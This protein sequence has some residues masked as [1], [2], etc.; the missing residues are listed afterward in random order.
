MSDKLIA[1]APAAAMVA[2]A[3]M[4]GLL[5]LQTYEQ[6]RDLA[7]VIANSD[8]APKDF[9]GKPD[10][11]L[12]A[13]IMGDE[14]GLAPMQ[15]VQNIAVINGRPS[16]WGDAVLALVRSSGLCAAFREWT[17]GEG[18]S[19]VA[20]CS[21]T[22]RDDP[23]SICQ[24]MFS[25]GDAKRAGLWGKQG[26]WQQYPARMLQM[27]A[28]GFALR[29]TYPDVLRGIWTREEAEDISPEPVNVTPPPA[30]EIVPAPV[31][32]Q[33]PRKEV[34]DRWAKG[35][36]SWAEHAVSEQTLREYVGL[37]PG[38]D[39]GAG[40]LELLTMAWREMKGGRTPEQIFQTGEVPPLLDREVT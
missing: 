16:L 23:K 8:L 10:N 15:A 5:R 30:P 29:D 28:R 7:K 12:I 9:R 24:R 40:H 39:P 19:L 38:D 25:V 34:L 1:L 17:E 6:A 33:S 26:P 27:R 4:R 32:R 11:V 14:L 22:R 20:Y 21:T 35:V 2:P 18:D 13:I 36:A 3:P 37:E 31:V